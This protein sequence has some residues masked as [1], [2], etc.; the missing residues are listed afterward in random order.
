M[1]QRERGCV[2]L[3][4]P[5]PWFGGKS[6]VAGIIWDRFG[7][8]RH[9]IEPFAGS[10]AVLLK[11][12]EDHRRAFETINDLDAHIAN[13]WRSVQLSPSVVIDYADWPISEADL[14]ARHRH[15]VERMTPERRD[16]FMSD[17][18]Y[19]EPDMAGWWLWGLCMWIGSGWCEPLGS[20]RMRVG[21]YRNMPGKWR[22][23][24]AQVDW[25]ALI[26]AI[27]ERIRR[28][29]AVCGDWKRVVTPAAIGSDVRTAGIFLD[30][31]YSKETGRGGRIYAQ[32]SL[33]V[34]HDVREWCKANGDDPDL[35]I[36]L[37]GLRGEHDELEDNGWEA[38]RWSSVGGFGKGN[39]SKAL[40]RRHLETIWFSPH[41][42]GGRQIDMFKASGIEIAG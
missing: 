32:E 21:T 8:V 30:P 36:A 2:A 29:K 37:C 33:T 16:R 22:G 40:E 20:R 38:V 26:H 18:L 23:I 42:L 31:P 6:R 12:P 11:R 27:R 15:L 28:V 3:K 35:R 5:F 7:D 4:A 39:D 41:C 13:F 9:Y 1:R 25:S 34:A 19:H 10:I 17:P 14:H 24:H